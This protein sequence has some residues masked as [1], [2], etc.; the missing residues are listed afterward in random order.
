MNKAGTLPVGMKPSKT[1]KLW[2]IQRY[3][4]IFSL[5]LYCFDNGSDIFVGVDL[6]NRCHFYFGSCVLSLMFCPGVTYGFFEYFRWDKEYRDWKLIVK[7]FVIF[8]IFFIPMTLFKL[9]QAVIKSEDGRKDV[10]T[11]K[12]LKNRPSHEEDQAKR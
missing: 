2:S 8:P 10:V 5:I 7:C 11:N 3:V 1:R 4:C 6:I 9:V 12:N